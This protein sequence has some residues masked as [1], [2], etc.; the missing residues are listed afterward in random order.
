MKTECVVQC[1]YQASISV[2]EIWFDSKITNRE[3]R[4]ETVFL[5]GEMVFKRYWEELTQ[6][7]EKNQ[8]QTL[9][10]I[11]LECCV[12]SSCGTTLD[13][14]ERMS[15]IEQSMEETHFSVV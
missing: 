15:E 3:S 1:S 2:C 9:D 5:H 7:M 11:W 6:R 10:G 12:C 4:L 8:S 13:K 14:N